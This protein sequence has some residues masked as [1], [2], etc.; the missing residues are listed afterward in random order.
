M[1]EKSSESEKM[2]ERSSPFEGDVATPFL[3][4]G[5]YNSRQLEQFPSAHFSFCPP[6]NK[7]W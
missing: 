5:E 6:Q 2:F 3:K 7:K 1:S 4:S